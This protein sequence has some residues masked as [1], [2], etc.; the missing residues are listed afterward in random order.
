MKTSIWKFHVL[1]VPDVIIAMP[2]FAQIISVGLQANQIYLWAVVDTNARIVQRKLRV[3]TTGGLLPDD[4][5]LGHY[6][7]TV[8]RDLSV[9]SNAYYEVLHIFDMGEIV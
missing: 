3:C 7:G 5:P 9:G 6:V 2:Q 1:D 8:Q 4:E